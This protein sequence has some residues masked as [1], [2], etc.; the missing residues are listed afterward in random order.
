MCMIIIF[1]LLFSKPLGQSRPNF[2]WGPL[3]KRECKIC[4]NGLTHMTK[5]AAMLIYGKTFS[6]IQSPMF[7]KHGIP[8]KRLSST[9][10]D[11]DLF[12]SKVRFGCLYFRMGKLLES[13]LMGKHCNR[14]KD[15]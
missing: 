5:M 9:K 7:L 8:H 10:F 13:H 12:T 15:V 1:K 6:R 2:I 11:L 4:E 3:G 14:E